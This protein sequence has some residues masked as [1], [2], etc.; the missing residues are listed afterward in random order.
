MPKTTQVVLGKNWH[1]VLSSPVILTVL[2]NPWPEPINSTVGVARTRS[3]ESWGCTFLYS[4][5]S[6]VCTIINS[7]HNFNFFC[8]VPT[9]SGTS[10]RQIG[11]HP[12]I[13]FRHYFITNAE[14]SLSQDGYESVDGGPVIRKCSN[15]GHDSYFVMHSVQQFD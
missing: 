7:K 14:I 6:F 9:P 5:S 10:L 4:L 1:P 15:L 13:I 3:V 12:G 8:F 2:C 11:P